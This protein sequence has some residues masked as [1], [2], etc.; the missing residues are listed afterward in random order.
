MVRVVALVP[1]VLAQELQRQP[2][3]HDGRARGGRV[4]DRQRADHRRRRARRRVREDVEREP[5]LLVRRL[6]GA[7]ARDTT[8]GTARSRP[9]EWP[10]P[11]K[12]RTSR[13]R[14]HRSRFD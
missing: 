11:A 4:Q 9:V 10:C 6:R 7:P 1:R 2:A 13:S 12:L 8:R 14:S 5:A 3:A